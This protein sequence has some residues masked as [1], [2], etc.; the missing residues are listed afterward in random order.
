MVLAQKIL[1]LKEMSPSR[2]K[3][4][5]EINELKKNNSTNAPFEYPEKKVHKS[6]NI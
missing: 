4:F 3:G 5:K 6:S 2:K 1:E